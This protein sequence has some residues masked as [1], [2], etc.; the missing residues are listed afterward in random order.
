MERAEATDPEV[1]SSPPS[2]R[3][4]CSYCKT[5]DMD[6]FPRSEH[7][8]GGRTPCTH[9]KAVRHAC[10]LLKNDAE[11][12][13]NP[14]VQQHAIK[15]LKIIKRHPAN[16]L[17]KKRTKRSSVPS[18]NNAVPDAIHDG[19]PA[20]AAPASQLETVSTDVAGIMTT[21]LASEQQEAAERRKFVER[22]IVTCSDRRRS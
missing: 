10:E 5:Q 7:D 22:V 12:E 15:L 9:C 19:T 16:E 3:A 17:P 8:R 1:R 4:T 14:A 11:N 18:T 2:K 6:A 21:Y 13:E 20:P